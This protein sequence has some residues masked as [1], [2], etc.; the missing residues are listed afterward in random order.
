MIGGFEKV[1]SQN[2]DLIF[3]SFK[4]SKYHSFLGSEN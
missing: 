4:I 3:T 2:K 1:N